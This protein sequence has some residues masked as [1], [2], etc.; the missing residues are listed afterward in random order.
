[1]EHDQRFLIFVH[2]GVSLVLN[3]KTITSTFA[4]LRLKFTQILHRRDTAR[5][6]AAT[7]LTSQCH[8]AVAC[9]SPRCHPCSTRNIHVRPTRYRVVVLTC[10]PPSLNK[11]LSEN[12]TLR[13]CYPE[14][15][16]SISNQAALD[17][18][19]SV[20]F[21]RE[22]FRLLNPYEL[23][24]ISTTAKVSKPLRCFC[25]DKTANRRD[26]PTTETRISSGFSL[27]R[28]SRLLTRT[29]GQNRPISRV[30]RFVVRSCNPSHRDMTFQIRFQGFR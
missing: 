5:P 3:F 19:S 6:L 16:P 11:T 17:L 18:I 8:N 14:A 25:L 26:R 23:K 29:T 24:L 7:K 13:T 21:G 9:G 15:T 27:P 30:A 4:S 28:P 10:I 2:L 20:L 22:L 1:M 12:R